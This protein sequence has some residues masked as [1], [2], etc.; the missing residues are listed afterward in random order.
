MATDGDHA[1]YLSVSST[2]ACWVYARDCTP[3]NTNHMMHDKHHMK[4]YMCHVGKIHRCT[5]HRLLCRP[6]DLHMV[7]DAY[8]YVHNPAS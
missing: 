7:L 2:V 1:F 6:R 8:K 5:L 3:H 4:L